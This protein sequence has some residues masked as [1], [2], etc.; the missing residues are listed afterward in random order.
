[1]Q[2]FRLVIRNPLEEMRCHGM[3]WGCALS[4]PRFEIV[5]GLP[6]TR[7]QSRLTCQN[8]AVTSLRSMRQES[9]RVAAG[10]DVMADNR[11]AR[12][13]SVGP[14]MDRIRI[15]HRNWR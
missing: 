15:G 14:G 12:I 11:K 6:T 3:L 9:V 10:I 5:F 4:E 7:P 2:F 8:V 13:D 1:V